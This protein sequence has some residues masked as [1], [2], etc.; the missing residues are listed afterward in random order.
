L[1]NEPL[2]TPDLPFYPYLKYAIEKDV[3]LHETLSGKIVIVVPDYRA[4]IKK[5]T[6]CSKNKIKVELDAKRENL[7][8]LLCKYY[9]VSEKREVYQGDIKFEKPEEEVKFEDEINEFYFY[10]I[11]KK[12]EIIDY[13][14]GTYL[15][16]LFYPTLGIEIKLDP[17]SIKSM[18]ENGENEHVE[19]K[20]K[21][22]KDT[23]EFVESVIAFSNSKG[24]IILL[25][26]TDDHK[27]VGV[28]QED[29]EKHFKKNL[30]EKNVREWVYNVIRDNC[31]PTPKITDNDIKIEEID[32]K[33]IVLIKVPE[34]ED[35]PY[36]VKRNSF[37]RVG[38]SDRVM[39]RF[40]LDQIYSKKG[41]P[42]TVIQY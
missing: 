4:R 22:P 42:S 37:I 11:T 16:C 15:G 12:G 25:G 31:E 14:E 9:C 10:L 38:S 33:K 39:T 5:L 3:G 28:Q 13:K 30:N 29:I 24:G 2:I 18:I 34:G 23:K 17:E 20:E 8:N 26:V 40:E 21:I 1:L 32:G 36:L 35:K 41:K 19:F 7:E 6:F 27:I